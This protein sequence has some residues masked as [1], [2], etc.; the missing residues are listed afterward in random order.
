MARKRLGVSRGI[1]GSS[2][3]AHCDAD[4]VINLDTVSL[5]ADESKDIQ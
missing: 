2:L 5:L 3:D 1:H 4:P